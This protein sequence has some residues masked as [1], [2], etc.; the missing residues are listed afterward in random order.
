MRYELAYLSLPPPQIFVGDSYLTIHNKEWVQSS[1]Q[2]MVIYYHHANV[3]TNNTHVYTVQPGD[4]AFFSPGTKGSHSRIGTDLAFDFFRFSL[5]ADLGPKG[6]IPHVARGMGHLEPDIRRAAVRVIDTSVYAMAFVWNL[7]CVVSQTTAVFRGF[8][9]LHEAEDYIRRNLSRRIAIPKMAEDLNTSPR[10]LLRAF[11]AEYDITIQEFILRQRM[12]EAARMLLTTDYSVKEVAA[13]IGYS[14][15]HH[16]NKAVRQSTGL[17][18][19][20]YRRL[21][22]LRQNPNGATEN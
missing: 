13:R 22:K 14:D 15:L 12:Q 17:P 3:I 16:F 21:G 18:P 10:H 6:A 19:R 9:I 7:M 11:R 5:P 20:E 1:D 8:E 4:I 2:W